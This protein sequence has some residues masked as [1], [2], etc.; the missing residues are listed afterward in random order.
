MKSKTEF[1]LN[2]FSIF[3]LESK[4]RIFLF[5]MKKFEAFKFVHSVYLFILI[6]PE[7]ED[8]EIVA[9]LFKSRSD[10]LF[11]VVKEAGLIEIWRKSNVSFIRAKEIARIEGLDDVDAD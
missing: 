3:A 9:D 5:M 2:T 4:K 7:A 11:I 10:R 8:V 1:T 6:R